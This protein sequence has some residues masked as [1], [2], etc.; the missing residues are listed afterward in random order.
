MILCFRHGSPGSCRLGQV[1]PRCV[2]DYRTGVRVI[3]LLDSYTIHCSHNPCVSL[4]ISIYGCSMVYSIQS[5]GRATPR[6]FSH[7]S[8]ERP[9]RV[10]MLQHGDRQSGPLHCLPLERQASAGTAQPQLLQGGAGW[11]S[12]VSRSQTRGLWRAKKQNDNLF[13]KLSILWT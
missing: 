13:S 6:A 7:R 9:A 4:I 3:I 11:Q 10:S 1:C 12:C 8:R 5:Q 2:V